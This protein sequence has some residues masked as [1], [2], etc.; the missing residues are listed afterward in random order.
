LKFVDLATITVSAGKGGNGCLSFRRE[1]FVPRGGPD[2]GDGGKGG[3]IF[4]EATP[5][6]QTLA[7]FQYRRRFLAENGT[8]GQGKNRF[9]KNGDDLFIPTPCGTLV[10]EVKTGK[11][12]ADL[13]VPGDRL[14]AAAGGRGGRGNARF[15]TSG[16]RAPRFSEKGVEG[17]SRIVRLE[18]KLIADV[19]LVGFPNAGKSTLLGAMSS[20]D[21]Q[22]GSY[23]FTTLSPNLGI[24]E[25]ETER[26]VIADLPGLIEGAHRNRGLG[27]TFLRHIERT[28][29]LAYVLDSDP[30]LE[31][32]EGVLR[33][34]ETL[35]DEFKAYKPDLLDL[36]SV[37][38]L[39]KVDLLDESGQKRLDELS[40]RFTT[41][42]VPVFVTSAKT[43][44]GVQMLVEYI[45]ETFKTAPKE[46]RAGRTFI[47]PEDDEAVH[48]RNRPVEIRKMDNGYRIVHAGLEN[49]VKKYQ[50]DQEEAL[51]RFAHLLKHYRVDQLLVENGAKPGDT[52]FIGD[53]EFDFIPDEEGFETEAQRGE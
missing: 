3:D 16:R 19:G 45:A 37:A 25:S 30:S 17:E 24:L 12:L 34:W 15:K 46:V 9:G 41:R 18:L 21:P 11:L 4:L 6:L 1:K 51:S 32:A 50:F 5:R 10:Y 44:R 14:L 49:V 22:T 2:G 29:I 7:D 36:P 43:G 40:K 8:N 42:N 47:I 35:R 53:M 39:N 26:I 28:R 48:V 27:H 13:S 23:P 52:V 20:A 33:Q 31:E 38:I